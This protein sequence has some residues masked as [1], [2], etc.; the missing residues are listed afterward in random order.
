M[1]GKGL[2]NDGDIPVDLPFRHF[3]MTGA[4]VSK[5]RH[6]RDAIIRSLV[7]GRN[8]LADRCR[9]CLVRLRP[10][11]YS[12]RGFFLPHRSRLFDSNFLD[13]LFNDFPD[14]R[15]IDIKASCCDDGIHQSSDDPQEEE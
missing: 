3:V 6:R 1:I 5:K 13:D 4:S 15:L 7:Y 11:G 2:F 8:L 14:I 10:F 9:F 12:W